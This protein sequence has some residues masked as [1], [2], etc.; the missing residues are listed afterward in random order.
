MEIRNIRA[1]ANISR[2]EF[3]R[4]YNIPYRTVEDWENGKGNAPVYV[5]E[6]LERAV[7]E[8]FLEEKTHKKP[9]DE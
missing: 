2:A 5:K 6:L 1:L 3:A 9:T 8:D 4:R 7:R